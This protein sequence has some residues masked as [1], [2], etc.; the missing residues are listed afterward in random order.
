MLSVGIEPPTG[1][2]ISLA[3]LVATRLD[4]QRCLHVF[5]NP[6]GYQLTVKKTAD[7]QHA[8]LA[9][10]AS[11]GSLAAHDDPL[12]YFS[13]STVVYKLMNADIWSEVQKSGILGFF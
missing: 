8:V 4:C 3:G 13:L 1:V 11:T 5:G 7:V 2:W 10:L 9:G 12:P 6:L